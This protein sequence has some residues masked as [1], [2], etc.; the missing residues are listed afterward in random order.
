MEEGLIARKQETSRTSRTL[1]WSETCFLCGEKNPL[2]LRIRFMRDGDRVY[3]E[4]EVEKERQGFKDVIHGGILAA[5]LD[6]TMGWAASLAF[7]RMCVTAEVAI[8]YLKPVRV[9]AKIIVT[10]I[11]VSCS[12]RLCTTEGK[13]RDESGVLL[14]RASGKYTPLTVEQS[15]MVDEYLIY[16]DGQESIFGLEERST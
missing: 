11:P 4:Y 3:T 6:E 7:D 16:P 15:R 13:V 9:G 10:G 8:R 5:L 1:P 12:R 2:G 14:A